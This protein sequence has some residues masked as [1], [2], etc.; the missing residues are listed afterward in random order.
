VRVVSFDDWRKL[1]RIEVESGAATGR[2]RVKL[3]S[4]ADMLSRL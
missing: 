2:P 4:T 3:V 1:D